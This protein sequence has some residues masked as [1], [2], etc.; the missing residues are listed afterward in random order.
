MGGGTGRAQRIVMPHRHDGPESFPVIGRS[1]A[2]CAAMSVLERAAPADVSV[3]VLGETGTGKELAARLVH[4]RSRRADQPFVAVNC[5]ALPE[6]LVESE[7][8]GH[9]AGAFT[10]AIRRRIGRFEQAHGGTLFLDEIGDLP[11]PAQAKLLRALQERVIERIGSS[12]SIPVDVRVIAATHRDLQAEV[13]NRCFR[14]DLYY[15]L[16]V[17]TARLPALR[18]RPGDVG[19]LAEHFLAAAQARLGRRDLHLTAAAKQRLAAHLWPG[20]V[21]ELENTVTR[22]VALAESGA[23]IDVA[24]LVLDQPVSLPGSPLPST[25]LRDILDFCEREILRRMLERHGGNRTHTA[26]ALHISRQALQQKLARWRE[27]DESA[28]GPAL[29][30]A[31]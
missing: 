27:R 22:A 13:A 16:S 10:G 21:R 26:A 9:E 29:A 19:A 25:D 7:L 30:D 31:G 2:L 6:Q 23:A 18:D 12:E 4:A 11:L 3:L 17:V 5:A 1:A 8:F 24:D 20:N 28:V 15:R 14:S